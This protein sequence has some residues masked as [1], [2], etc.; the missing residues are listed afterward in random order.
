MTLAEVYEALLLCVLMLYGSCG[1]YR[2]EIPCRVVT[3]QQRLAR[4]GKLEVNR[5]KDSRVAVCEAS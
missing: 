4:A 1:V 5:Q 3:C 2:A